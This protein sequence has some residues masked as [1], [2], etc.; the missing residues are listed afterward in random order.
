MTTLAT[1]IN[2]ENVIPSFGIFSTCRENK[3]GQELAHYTHVYTKK[4]GL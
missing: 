1:R 2:A 4:C 3:N